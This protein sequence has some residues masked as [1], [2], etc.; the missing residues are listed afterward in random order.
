[1]NTQSGYIAIVGRPNVGKSTLLNALLGQKISITSPKPQTT[2][3]NLLGIKTLE[4]QQLIF[5]DTPGLQVSPT[6]ALNRLMNK[7]ALGVVQ[8]VDVI[9]FVVEGM[10]WR[11]EDDWVLQRFKNTQIPVILVVNKVDKISPR[12]RL[13]PFLQK[14]TEKYNFA[15]ICPLSAKDQDNL[16]GLEQEIIA[17]LPENDFI[18]SEDQLTD[19][20]ERFLVAE[21]IREKL[22]LLLGEELPYQTTVEIEQFVEE[23]TI[24]KI[25]GLIWVERDGQKAIVIGKSGAMLKKIGSQARQDI[26][27]LLDKKVFLQ[28]WVKVKADWSD[29]DRAL[30][31]LG[32]SE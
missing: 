20:S 23:K 6:K 19:K 29:N 7:N 32:Y 11:D 4:K 21:L 22:M 5:V 16:S 15:A 30:R 13:L 3:H 31:Q 26:E 12:E 8:D 9:V 18:F 17:R 27:K 2:R 14:M 28:L 10:Q 1:M 25:S 24:T